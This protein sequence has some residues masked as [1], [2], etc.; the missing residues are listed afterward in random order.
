MT[1]VHSVKQLVLP[2]F[3]DNGRQTSGLGAKE[4]WLS[5]N[6]HKFHG[7]AMIIAFTI[8][9]PSAVIYL[10]SGMPRAFTVH[11]MVQTAAIVIAF[12]SAAYAMAK[13]WGSFEVRVL[14]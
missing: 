1:R 14:P 10:R 7:I 9:M 6:W 13:S 5:F 11:W 3:V 4:K 8:L 2:E 12:M